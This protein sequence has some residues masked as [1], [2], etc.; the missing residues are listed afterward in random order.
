LSLGGIDIDIDIETGFAFHAA[1]T[2]RGKLSAAA[3]II[4]AV[5]VGTIRVVVGHQGSVQG[6]SRKKAS[7]QHGVSHRP[8]GSVA[9]VF[10]VVLEFIVVFAVVVV[11]VV[12]VAHSGIFG[13]CCIQGG[14]FLPG[15]LQ[16]RR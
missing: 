6:N 13:L 7:Q 2:D 4:V 14:V 9:V 16:S 3:A 11:V 15:N 10:V 8:D 12:V 1:V 5:V